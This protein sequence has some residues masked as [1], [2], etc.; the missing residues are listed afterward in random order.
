MGVRAAP[1]PPHSGPLLESDLFSVESN[2]IIRKLLLALI[3]ISFLS[4]CAGDDQP[5]Q[6]PTVI[7]SQ[8][9]E[10]N[11]ILPS[12]DG[13]TLINER[14]NICHTLDRIEKAKKSRA[15]WERIVARMMKEGARLEIDK[16]AILIDYLAETY[17]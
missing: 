17:K 6:P 11:E 10:I 12:I 8:S 3:I 7:P 14:C 1:A 15:D 5:T 16:Q 2:M 9:E 13:E 4:A